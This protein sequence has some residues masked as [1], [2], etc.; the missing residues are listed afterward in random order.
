MRHGI[1]LILYYFYLIFS[2]AGGIT[3]VTSFCIKYLL[4][5]NTISNVPI[6][7]LIFIVAPLFIF[8]FLAISFILSGI[9][10]QLCHMIFLPIIFLLE[11]D[12]FDNHFDSVL[13]LDDGL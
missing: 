1:A 10:A 5:D 6:L 4:K 2:V 8:G 3:L 9:L 12:F 7:P 11:R 13:D